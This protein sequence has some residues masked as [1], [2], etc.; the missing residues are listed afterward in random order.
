MDP[1]L[2]DMDVLK[3][4]NA[5]L[6]CE[7]LRLQL[8]TMQTAAHKSREELQAI[9]KAYEVEG[10]RLYRAADGVWLYQPMVRTG[11]DD[12]HTIPD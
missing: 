2:S 6:R 5:I 10:Y 12:A 3:L 7:N 8:E 1:T 4:E 11:S 9:V